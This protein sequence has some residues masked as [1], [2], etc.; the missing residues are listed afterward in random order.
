MPVAAE[1][2][3]IGEDVAHAVVGKGVIDKVEV[4]PGWST[5]DEPTYEFYF[6]VDPT[7]LTINSGVV[8]IDLSRHLLDA[9]YERGDEHLPVV[10]LLDER[11]WNHWLNA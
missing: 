1:I 8:H 4:R 2:Q 3:Q 11:D 10:H 6:R 7:R 5:S 9:L